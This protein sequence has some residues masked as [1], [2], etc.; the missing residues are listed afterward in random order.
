MEADMLTPGKCSV[1]AVEITTAWVESNT[2]WIAKF[3]HANVGECTTN[4]KAERQRMVEERIKRH[5]DSGGCPA[6]IKHGP[7]RQSDT[8]CQRPL[9]HDGNHQVV[10]EV[11]D[12]EGSEAYVD[13]WGD[14][15]ER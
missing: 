1:C 3:R 13:D 10:V 14:V 9:G 4:L 11:W 12:W 8:F 6:T 15:H 7:G 2:P 5:T